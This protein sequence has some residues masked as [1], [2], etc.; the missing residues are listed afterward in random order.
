MGNKIKLSFVNDGKP[1]I[2]PHMTVKKQEELL[3]DMTELEKKYKEGTLEYN[4]EVNKYMV[5]RIL[6]NVDESVTLDN[7]NNMHPDD[8]IKLFNMFWSGGRELS[9][10][11][12]KFRDKK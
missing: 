7:I 4:R 8:Y 5:L 10:D 6:Q 9:S 2:V 1:F 3:E 12:D 11:E